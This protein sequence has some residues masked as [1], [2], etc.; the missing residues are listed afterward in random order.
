MRLLALLAV[1]IPATA[2]ADVD[3][4]ANG[5]TDLAYTGTDFVEISGDTGWFPQG[6]VAQLRLGAKVAGHTIVAAGASARACWDTEMRAGFL[7]RG[8]TGYLD[9]AYGAEVTLKAR[10][11]TRVLGRDINWEGN[12]P[13]PYSDLL[14]AGETAFDPAFGHRVQVSDVT[15]SI[16]LLSTDIIGDLISITGIS[17]GLHLRATP[18]MTTSFT[19]TKAKLAGDTVDSVEDAITLDGPFG[20]GKD[21]AMQAEGLVRY[22]PSLAFGVS[23][24]VKIFGISVVDWTIATVT[25]PLPATERTVKLT[26]DDARIPLP[27]LDGIGD[28]A[29]MDFASGTVQELRVENPGEGTLSL[30]PKAAGRALISRLDIPPGGEGLLQV[31]VA[32]PAAFDAGPFTVVLATNDPDR[33]DVALQL[34]REVGGTDPG[35]P[36]SDGTAGGCAA[37]GG[38]PGI[39]VLLGFLAL[40]KR[41][42]YLA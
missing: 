28:G 12:I 3:R 29:R 15:S 30:E 24:D 22:A 11:H 17:G 19:L 7:G 26:G 31:F 8:G 40:G 16:P 37:G 14:L 33:G 4:C 41:R 13:L 38:T 10:I 25:M 42:R 34:G 1:A 9:V 35:T 20:A 32:A 5:D 6:S 2:T 39:L 18:A 23:F 36:P 27:V 21:V